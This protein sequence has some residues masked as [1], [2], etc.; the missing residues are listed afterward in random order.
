MILT[1]ANIIEKTAGKGRNAG[2]INA[3]HLSGRERRDKTM[4]QAAIMY[5]LHGILAALGLFILVGSTADWDEEKTAHT[6]G[7][8]RAPRGQSK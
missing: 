3:F 2:K 5:T 7:K 1:F 4:S 6:S 8:T